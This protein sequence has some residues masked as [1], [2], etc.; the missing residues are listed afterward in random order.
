MRFGR[1]FSV[2]VCG[3]A[4]LVLSGCSARLF[5]RDYRGIYISSLVASPLKVAPGG[6]VTINVTAVDDRDPWGVYDAMLIEV[7]VTASAGKL[8]YELEK[9]QA[10]AATVP[11]PYVFSF[12]SGGTFYLRV[13]DSPQDVTI[14]ATAGGDSASRTVQ[15]R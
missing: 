10:D 14:T 1:V 5:G 13:P 6:I 2:A 12:L 11:Q 15:V 4:V 9:A 7:K 8:Y 3:L